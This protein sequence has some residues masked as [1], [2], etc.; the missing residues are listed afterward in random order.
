MLLGAVDKAGPA[1]RRPPNGLVTVK[2]K[3]AV[4]ELYKKANRPYDPMQTDAHTVCALGAVITW[5]PAGCHRGF[6][7]K[8]SP[9]HGQAA[10]HARSLHPVE[11]IWA[12]AM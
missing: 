9:M 8:F 4:K 3:D 5:G 2:L 11:S 12:Q 6:K 7:L 10:V 1:E